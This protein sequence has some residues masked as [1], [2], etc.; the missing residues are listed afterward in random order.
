VIGRPFLDRRWLQQR[1]VD[2]DAWSAPPHPDPLPAITA[3]ARTLERRGIRLI[4]LPVPGKAT[5]HPAQLTSRASDI[6][7]APRNASFPAFVQALRDAGVNVLD[8]APLLATHARRVARPMY[9]RTDTHWTPEAVRVVATALA[10]VI[11]PHLSREAPQNPWRTRDTSVSSAGDL[12]ALLA[13]P[14]WTPVP[15]Q[16]VT[17][18]QVLTADGQPWRPDP[19]AEV[20]LLGDSYTNIYSSAGLGWGEGAGLAEHLSLA[21]GRGVDRFVQNDAGASATREALARAIRRTPERLD[22]KTVVVYQFAER[23][24]SFGDWR[25]EQ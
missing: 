4:V 1:I 12:A 16:Q 5:V 8:I 2:S 18:T 9:L 14:S 17:L 23:E 13:L 24:L 6:T 3:F 20:L 10:E 11:G 25:L 15:P 21:L 19:T 7:P 22:V